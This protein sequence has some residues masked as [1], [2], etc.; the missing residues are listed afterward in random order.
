MVNNYSI[1]ELADIYYAKVNSG[2]IRRHSCIFIVYFEHIRHIFLV[3]LLLT[4][5]KY[6]P[7]GEP[8]SFHSNYSAFEVMLCVLPYLQNHMI[9]WTTLILKL[10]MNLG[11]YRNWLRTNVKYLKNHKNAFIALEE[12]YH[13]IHYLDL[14][15]STNLKVHYQVWDNFRQLNAEAA[16]GGVL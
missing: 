11:A 5:D 2:S 13:I 15:N 7:V 14:K 3:F 4:L 8:K 10:V 12:R 1:H 6:M 9:G 16:T